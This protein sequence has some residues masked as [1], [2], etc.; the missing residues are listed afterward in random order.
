MIAALS[1]DFV[2]RDIHYFFYDYDS[3]AIVLF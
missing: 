2:G 1:R 3:T